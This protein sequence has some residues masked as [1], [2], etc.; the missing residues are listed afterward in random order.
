M[1]AGLLA[2]AGVALVVSR[3]LGLAHVPGDLVVRGRHVTVYVPIVT[4][5]VLSLILTGLMWLISTR[6]R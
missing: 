2:V 6:R 1:L 5:V 4:S 3:R